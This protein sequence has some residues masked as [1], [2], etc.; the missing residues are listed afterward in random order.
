[1]LIARPSRSVTVVLALVAAILALAPA[2][3]AESFRETV[4]RWDG[5]AVEATSR[6]AD[7]LVLRS[8]RLTLSLGKG[9]VAKVLAGGETVGLFL[10]G[11]GTLR[12]ISDDAVEHP[13]VRYV[14]RKNTGL[15]VA[16]GSSSGH[17]R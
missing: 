4:D 17:G 14:A 3:R 16:E 10:S 15:D 2:A 13:V 5:V 7:G 1:M 8:G 6:S 9:R 11:E 12:H